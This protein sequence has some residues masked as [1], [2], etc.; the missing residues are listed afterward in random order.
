MRST[1]IL[2]IILLIILAVFIFYIFRKYEASEEEQPGS[3]PEITIEE[4]SQVGLGA[5]IVTPT[6]RLKADR[7]VYQQDGNII[8]QN[9]EL[10]TVRGDRLITISG[11]KAEIVYK[12]DQI[13]RA[14][15]RRNVRAYTDDGMELK[16]NR[17][18]YFQKRNCVSSPQE[19]YF[20][21]G[22]LK[23]KASRFLYFLDPGIIQFL[24]N[25]EIEIAQE[26]TSEEKGEGL[27]E[28]Q[29]EISEETNE[30]IPVV[31]AKPPIFV[32]CG[33]LQLDQKRHFFLLDGGVNVM[34]GE[35]YLYS[36][37]ITGQLT[38][39]NKYVSQIKAQVAV[40]SQ[41]GNAPSV[42]MNQGKPSSEGQKLNILK[43]SEGIKNLFCQ[44]L[45]LH[46]SSDEK[47]S[48]QTMEAS[49]NAQLEIIIHSAKTAQAIERR[50]I[51]GEQLEIELETTKQQI[52]R[53][54]AKEKAKIEIF[55]PNNPHPEK[56]MEAN[57]I[58]GKF[59][60]TT[61]E[62]ID[63]EFIRDFRF[64]QANLE[65]HAEKAIYSDKEGALDLSGNPQILKEGNKVSAEKIY[66]S[67]KDE[68]LLA[69]KKVVSE[70]PPE[71]LEE[72]FE[73]S[74]AEG[75]IIFNSDMMIYNH[76]KRTIH[77]FGLVK[78]LFAGNI[79]WADR[80][81]IKQDEGKL[82]AEGNVKNLLLQEPEK[83]SEK[84]VEKLEVFSPYMDYNNEEGKIEYRKGVQMSK[85]NLQIKAEE[86]D[87]FRMEGEK[88]FNRA[89][90][91]EK[92]IVIREDMV[93]QGDTADYDFK[94]KIMIVR[95]EVA[96]FIQKGK[97]DHIGKILTFFLDNDKMI[98]KA[99]EDGR[100]KTIYRP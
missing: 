54:T 97:M 40:K 86:V 59:N 44:K 11:E 49:G 33:F 85:G 7:S 13:R 57:I 71:S 3:E 30:D 100:V 43:L 90:A 10:Q 29:E 89:L 46:F 38:E 58:K 98:L 61:G 35:D 92:V 68:D 24:G 18:N 31:S 1:R 2:Q 88:G 95:G 67:L 48:P 56:T 42:Q 47:N 25:V 8:Y 9:F 6:F 41:F 72:M 60:P 53:F 22:S 55:S 52:E 39:D 15:L 73:I 20:S 12:R 4:N 32:K 5:E 64:F 34:R 14:V 69:Q 50:L 16:S 93:V 87:L 37:R 74:E 99:N 63:A 77:Y 62:L 36:R 27:E 23:G 51:K 26:K 45:T 91:R 70:L 66:Y 75:P 82:T 83:D 81:L 84:Q 80:A 17:L 78:G 19:V 96:R 79:L 65:A 28:K 21:K 76:S 94:Q